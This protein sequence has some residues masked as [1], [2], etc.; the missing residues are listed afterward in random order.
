MSSSVVLSLL[1]TFAVGGALGAGV[2]HFTATAT[3]TC[4]A[5]AQPSNE[6]M[7]R[8]LQKTPIPLTGYRT[9]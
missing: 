4:A 9:Y 3:V 5:P 6:G 1:A 7:N 2:T 8:L